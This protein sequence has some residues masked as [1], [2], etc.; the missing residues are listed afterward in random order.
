MSTSENVHNY[1]IGAPKRPTRADY[2]ESLRN[3]VQNIGEL[4]INEF[5]AFAEDSAAIA[6]AFERRATLMRRPERCRKCSCVDL[7][8][9]HRPDV[10]VL[11]PASR[12]PQHVLLC[13]KCYRK[14]SPANRSLRMR[15]A[16]GGWKEAI[17]AWYVANPAGE[18]L[19]RN[20]RK[21]LEQD[22]DMQVDV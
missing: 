12:R 15:D 4:H 18:Y 16:V 13:T 17:R 10:I 19:S 7:S 14:I 3:P 8:L 20:A 22:V 9:R 2:E 6:V 21:A 11:H 5:D 1:T